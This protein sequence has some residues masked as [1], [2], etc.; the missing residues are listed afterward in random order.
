MLKLFEDWV[1]AILI[2]GALRHFIKK[3]KKTRNVFSEEVT[4]SV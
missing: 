4:G 2:P 3:K 1:R